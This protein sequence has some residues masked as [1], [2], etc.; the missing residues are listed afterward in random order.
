[1][2]QINTSIT[3]LDIG[4]N[5]VDPEGLQRFMFGVRMNRTLRSLCLRGSLKYSQCVFFFK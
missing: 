5:K 4:S 2:L 3:I 1:M